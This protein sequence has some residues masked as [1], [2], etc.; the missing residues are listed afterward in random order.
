MPEKN[1]WNQIAR[2]LYKVSEGL[3]FRQGKHCRERW[4]SYMQNRKMK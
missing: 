4:F 2:Q 3:Y 1:K